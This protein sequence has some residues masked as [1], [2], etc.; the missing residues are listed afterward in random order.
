MSQEGEGRR[1][2]SNSVVV[3]RLQYA[4]AVALNVTQRALRYLHFPGE[5]VILLKK[6]TSQQ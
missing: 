5:A 3:P 4:G 6:V 1:S 2:C